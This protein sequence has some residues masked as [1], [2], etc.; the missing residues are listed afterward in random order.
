MLR[1]LARPTAMGRTERPPR[2]PDPRRTEVFGRGLPD[3]LPA[4]KTAVGVVEKAQTH[5]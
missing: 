5:D 3:G 1:R 4:F 2:R